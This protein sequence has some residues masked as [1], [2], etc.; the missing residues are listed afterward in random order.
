MTVSVVI[1]ERPGLELGS[2]ENLY[3][4]Q[5]PK[6][7]LYLVD[8]LLMHMKRVEHLN[9]GSVAVRRMISCSTSRVA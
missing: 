2:S 9:S 1:V 6:I 8:Q 3:L 4:F 5:G 7:V